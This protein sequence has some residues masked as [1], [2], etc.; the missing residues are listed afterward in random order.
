MPK[1]IE[2]DS[3]SGTA[4]TGHEWDGIRE[5]DTPMPKWWVTTFLVCIA[6][7]IV[8]CVL[9]PSVP[10]IVG[11]TTGL[12]GY[13]GRTRVNDEMAAEAKLRAGDMGRIATLPFAQI[14]ADPR[15]SEMAQTGGRI[16]F[17]NNCQPCHGAGGAGAPGYPAL[18]AGAWIWGGTIEAIETTLVHGIRSADPQARASQMPKFADGILTPAQIEQVA[19]YVFTEFYGHAEPRPATAPGAAVF[20]ENCAACHGAAGMGGRDV[21]A[22]RLASRVHLYGNTRDAVISQ[23][24]APR[25]GVMPAW[26]TRLDAATLRSVALYVHALGGGE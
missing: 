23:I 25:A 7:A 19:D 13:N 1:P 24:R 21:G 17:A 11:H 20:A 16:A 22:P 9:Y 2:K 12:L 4:T 3:L 8:Y 26:G 5:L 18:A 10:Y 6:I 15:L 14:S